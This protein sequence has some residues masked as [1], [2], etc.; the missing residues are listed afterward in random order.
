MASAMQRRVPMGKGTVVVHLSRPAHFLNGHEGACLQSVAKTIAR[1]RHYEFGGCY[2]GARHVSAPLFFVPDETLVR[3]EARALG[4]HGEDDLFGGIV[5]R[6]FMAT[7]VITHELVDTAAAKP[8]GWSGA[9]G[10]R[11][12]GVVLT[13]YSAFTPQDVRQATRRLLGIGAARAKM[14]RSAGARGQRT[15]TSLD[16]VEALLDVVSADDLAEHGIVLE[17]NLVPVATLSVGLVS[18]AGITMA[19]HGHQRLTRDNDGREVYGGSDLFC[20]RGG[21]DTLE[22]LAL[23]AVTR[24]AITQSRAYDAATEEYD[25]IASRR[26]YDVGQGIDGDGHWRSGVLEA[27]W[28]AGGA[29]G[30]EVAA[31]EA[32]A[33][34]P[35]V[36]AVHVGTVEAY[37]ERLTPPRDALVHF[38]GVDPRS[39]PLLRYTRVR[40]LVRRAA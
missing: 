23:D 24:T 19:Y 40:R 1:L 22:G 37:G 18:V 39:G 10:Q 21:W 32:F 12:R 15:L 28:R 38:H 16:D 27:S 25:I 11:V 29:S 8:D 5:V 14:P 9:F 13:G 33:A 36:D 4:I 20:V 6:P 31:V 35:S 7:K 34:D 26:N 2:D 30:A 17:T 3:A